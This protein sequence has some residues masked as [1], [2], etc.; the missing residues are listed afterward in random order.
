MQQRWHRHQNQQKRR[1]LFTIFAPLFLF[2]LLA[3]P[4]AG[5]ASNSQ[6]A[7]SSGQGSGRIVNV[8]AGE[9][10]WGSIAS[11]LGGIHA[12]VTSIVQSPTGDPHDYESTTN[13]A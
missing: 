7:V 3:L 1:F 8:V 13:D 12:S 11:Q 5:C 2:L 9:N 6:S 10:F 4:L